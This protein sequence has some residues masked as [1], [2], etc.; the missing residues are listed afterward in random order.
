[1]L[2]CA[3]IGPVYTVLNNYTA[4]M[5]PMHVF[6]HSEWVNASRGLQSNPSPLKSIAHA[7]LFRHYIFKC[8]RQTRQQQSSAKYLDTLLHPFYK[9]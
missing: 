3:H 1:M 2:T 7:E 5:G 8:C 6:E 9:M 4:Y